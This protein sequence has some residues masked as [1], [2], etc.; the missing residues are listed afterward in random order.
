[1]PAEKADQEDLELVISFVIGAKTRALP[2]RFLSRH[3]VIEET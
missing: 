1:M 2:V 3:E